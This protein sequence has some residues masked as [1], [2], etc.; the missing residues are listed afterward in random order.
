MGPS[1]RLRRVPGPH[2]PRRAQAPRHHLLPRRPARRRRRGAAAA[3]HRRRGRLQRGLPRGCPGARRPPG[4][5]GRR[6]LAG[7]QRHPVRRAADG[8]GLGFGRRRPHRRQ[9]H[10]APGRGRG[11]APGRRGAGRPGHAPAHR[12]RAFRGAHPRLDQ[13]ARAR[14]AQGGALAGSRELGGQG[15]PGRPQPAHPGDRRRPPRPRRHGLGV[16]RRHLRRVVAVRGRRDAAQPG[17]HDRGRHDRGEQEH[18]GG[19]GAGPA[20]EPDPWRD[21][22]WREVPRS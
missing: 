12:R 10:P 17:E 3:P 22:S 6:R 2:R 21:A 16:G 20:R 4:R 5:V 18:R 15:P 19:A 1:G 11:E 8:V 9:W 14:R 13:P 7:G